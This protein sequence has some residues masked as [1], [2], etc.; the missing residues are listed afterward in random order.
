MKGFNP[1]D[2]QILIVDGT[3]NNFQS[4]LPMLEK[5]GYEI[6]FAHNERQMLEAVE[7]KQPDLIWI[8]LANQKVDGLKIGRILNNNPEHCQIPL[9]FLT[10]N[11]EQEALIETF[12]RGIVDSL[13]KPLEELE[14]LTCIKTHLKLKRNRDEMQK[15]YT[16]LE[17][18]VNTDPL[19]EVANRRAL[20]LFGER[21]FER[22][23]RY[24]QSFSVL[25]IDIDRF[26]QI[27]DTYGH[28]IGDRVLIY[29]T[30]IVTK[31]LRKA[32]CFGRFGGEE[33]LAFLPQ[34]LEDRAFQVAE[35]IRNRIAKASL[36]VEEK[37]VTITVSIGIASYYPDDDSLDTI[38]KRADLALYEA[39]ERGRNQTIANIPV[40]RS[41][42]NLNEPLR[43]KGRSSSLPQNQQNNS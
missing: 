19:T 7:K 37:I 16:E 32:D 14:A 20:L 17:K 41:Q 8:D 26:K 39:K 25:T 21:E 11:R 6:A 30:Q 35:R 28:D 27:N 22:A 2:F 13:N 29:M 24:R 43:I 9:I 1:E 40:E 36:K 42:L 33:F 34:T 3:N 23:R 12:D 15:A 4:I 31:S 10:A 5:M 18:L 38:L